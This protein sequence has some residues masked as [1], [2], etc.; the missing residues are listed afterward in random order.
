MSF[1]FPRDD[2]DNIDKLKE[3]MKLYLNIDTDVLPSDEK[4]TEL[5]KKLD[6]SLTISNVKTDKGKEGIYDLLVKL[7]QMEFAPNCT[8]TEIPLRRNWLKNIDGEFVSK[9]ID[10]GFTMRKSLVSEDGWRP[11][12]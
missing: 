12:L 1:F 2:G 6:K 4:V 5:L 3:N 9:C 8:G 11:L 7:T 10:E